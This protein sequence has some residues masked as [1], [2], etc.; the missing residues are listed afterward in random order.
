[1]SCACAALASRR[2]LDSIYTKLANR[3]EKASLGRGTGQHCS[4]LPLLKMSALS[5]RALHTI[6]APVHLDPRDFMSGA[7]SEAATGS[8][9]RIQHHKRCSR[10]SSTAIGREYPVGRSIFTHRFEDP[11]KSPKRY[12]MRHTHQVC[13][14]HGRYWPAL[15]SRIMYTP[16]PHRCTAWHWSSEARHAA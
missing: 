12:K 9:D 4:T 16:V 1:M 15:S 3:A 10:R 14:Q 6:F 11:R 13:G 5:P 7:D 2:G 8:R